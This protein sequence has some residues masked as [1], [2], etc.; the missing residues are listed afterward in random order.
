M[1]FSTLMLTT[2][3]MRVQLRRELKNVLYE[4]FT[5][6]L[7]IILKKL[8]TLFRKPS[9]KALVEELQIYDKTTKLPDA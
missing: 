4:C 3:V 5:L 7:N 9:S 2:A 6:Q 8:F 1:K